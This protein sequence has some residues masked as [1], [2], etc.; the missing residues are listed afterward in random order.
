MISLDCQYSHIP[1]SVNIFASLASLSS[2]ENYY[3]EQHFIKHLSPFIDLLSEEI[4]LNKRIL[5]NQKDY[6]TK[7]MDYISSNSESYEEVIKMAIDQGLAAEWTNIDKFKHFARL[8]LLDKDKNIKEY[9]MEIEDYIKDISN[10][11]FVIDNNGN[12]FF[13]DFIYD[14]SI[15]KSEFA[16]FYYKICSLISMQA[17]AFVKASV[18]NF[19]KE[20]DV[21]QLNEGC[22][23]FIKKA[24]QEKAQEE[25]NEMLV[26]I[27]KELLWGTISFFI[28][29]KYT[30]DI[31]PTSERYNSFGMEF[32]GFDSL[33]ENIALALT[34]ETKN[35]DRV[36]EI[37]QIN[38]AI[39][40]KKNGIK[41]ACISRIDVYNTSVEPSK[42]KATDI[43]GVVVFS[44]EERLVVEFHESKN[45]KNP[46]KDA[47]KDIKGNLIQILNENKKGYR[48]YDVKNY[49]VK[50]VFDIK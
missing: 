2:W 11:Y 23:D 14:K 1:F 35:P 40:Y 19:Y 15:L 5:A 37:E 28:K 42:A 46:V 48:I 26:E 38:R 12:D 44:Q 22:K 13:V 9:M 7:E 45:T 27:Y 30:F 16:R 32:N 50:L 49:G 18:G 17:D 33:T 34:E 3:T 43:D 47:K 4:Y 25:A 31:T 10:T 8:P 39:K 36:H 24:V 6:E 41:L 29:N 21:Q 20:E